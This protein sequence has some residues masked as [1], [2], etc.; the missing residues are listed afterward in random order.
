MSF[1]LLRK[2][3]TGTLVLTLVTASCFAQA[4]VWYL[5][6]ELAAEHIVALCIAETNK[7]IAATAKTIFTSEN[8]GET[9]VSVTTPDTELSALCVT[10]AGK[11]MIGSLQGGI[12]ESADSGKGWTSLKAPSQSVLSMLVTEGGE[13]IAGTADHGIVGSA[14]GGKSWEPTALNGGRI[15]CL[16]KSPDGRIYAGTQS[17]VFR[18]DDGGKTWR[19]VATGGSNPG[20]R[21]LF[22]A[23]DSS[24]WA[25]TNGAEL[26]R[27]TN[28]GGH[29][30]KSDSGI[31]LPYIRAIVE[32]SD[33]SIVAA[34]AS[35]GVYRTTDHGKT[36]IVV[37]LT[38]THI[39]CLGIDKNDRL[40]CGTQ[41]RGIFRS[42]QPI[43][44]TK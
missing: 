11:L 28:G 31:T 18:S 6:K 43:T 17:G 8:D 29:W 41:D 21:C 4:D 1:E 30:I 19:S 20:V 40:W 10:P 37:D 14:D 3:S 35:G 13:L 26:F 27:S 23:E 16:E 2:L 7:V 34:T 44:A 22:A 25:A 15:W 42:L 32:A 24:I 9:W 36:W 38:G 5:P 33:R 12:C 39:T